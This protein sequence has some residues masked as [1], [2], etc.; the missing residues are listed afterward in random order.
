MHPRHLY[1]LLPLLLIAGL[2]LAW[3][4]GLIALPREYDPLAPLDVYDEPTF[5]TGLKLARLRR[6]PAYCR[7]ALES[8]PLDYLPVADMSRDSGCV[9]VDAVRIARSSVTFNSSFLASCPLAVAYAMFE[10]HSLQPLA[11]R[12]FAQ[13]ATGVTHWGSYACRNIRGS[14][15]RSDHASAAALDLA[16]VS[17]ADGR[18]IWIGRDWADKDAAEDDRNAAFLHALHDG[19]CRFFNVVLGPDFDAAHRDHFHLGMGD[20]FGACR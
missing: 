5:V 13:P 11:R 17:L 7:A 12:Y 14:E 4:L 20:G 10:H 19:A 18:S 1:W 3:W 16:A 2:V 15:R 6:N 9:L 8:S